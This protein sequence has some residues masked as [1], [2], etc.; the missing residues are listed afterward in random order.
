MIETLDSY[1]YEESLCMNDK[2]DRFERFSTVLLLSKSN[3][4][5]SKLTQ[6][7]IITPFATKEL[8]GDF[9]TIV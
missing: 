1:F 7:K 9:L 2:T 8:I 6:E 4:S 5:S 3:R